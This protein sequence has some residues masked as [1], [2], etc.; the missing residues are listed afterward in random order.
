MWRGTKSSGQTTVIELPARIVVQLPKGLPRKLVS[1]YLEDC[2]K[3]LSAL[4]A[5]L[6]ERDY[7]RARVFGHQLKGTGSPYGFPDLTTLGAAI[8]GAA[9]NQD[10]PELDRLVR[11]LEEYLRAVE[12]AGE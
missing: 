5:A 8:E 2:Q 3:D 6:V 10:T 12:I 7:E 4:N 9:V 11:Q 1:G